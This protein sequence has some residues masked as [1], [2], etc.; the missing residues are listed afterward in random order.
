MQIE[1]NNITFLFMPPQDVLA[2]PEVHG[3][4]CIATI[5]DVWPA[6]DSVT[7][8]TPCVGMWRDTF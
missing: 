4:E 3:M 6:T 2:G 5:A 1:E 8:G 7:P